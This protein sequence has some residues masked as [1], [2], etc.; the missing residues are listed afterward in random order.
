MLLR[1]TDSGKSAEQVWKN[2]ELDTQMGGA[3]KVGDYIYASGHQNRNWFCIDLKTGETKYRV[4][5]MAPCNVI[6]ADGMLYCY[7]ERG[8]MNLVK[9]NP[10]KFELVS[11]FPVTL[12][13]D[14][15]W[16]HPVIHEG[17]LYI[18]HGDALM[19]YSI[20]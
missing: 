10:E 2:D 14:Q 4:R 7:S 17:V 16:A 11:S 18:R 12:G 6:Y 8:T 13:T 1:L 15:H 5:D 19:A 9:P 20:K 3:V